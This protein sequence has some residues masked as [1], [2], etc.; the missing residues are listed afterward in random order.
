MMHELN[1]GA[2]SDAPPRAAPADPGHVQSIE[3]MMREAEGAAD[4]GVR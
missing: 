1:E 2:G 3:E 4:A